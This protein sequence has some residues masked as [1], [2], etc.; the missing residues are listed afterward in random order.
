MWIV[1]LALR[2]PHTFIVMSLAILVA[3]GY[4]V[5]RAPT[6]I[7]PTVDLPVLSVVWVYGGLPTNEF[8]QQITRPAEFALAG[9]VGDIRSMESQTLDGASII[10]VYFQEG[11]DVPS[12]TAQVTA[13]MQAITRIM[14][15]GTQPP[16]IVRYNA[17]SVAIMEVGFSSEVLSEAEVFDFVNRTARQQLST[18]RGARFPLPA[19]GAPRQIVVDIDPDALRARGL[20]PADVTQAIV[21]QN[22]TLPTGNVRMGEQELRV[23]LNSSPPDIASLN[24]MPVQRVDGRTV[25]VRDVAF[26]HD[27]NAIQTNVARRDGTRAIILSVLKSGGDASTTQITA[28]IRELLPRLQASAPPG[29]EIEVLSDQSV[30]VSRA[31]SGLVIEA[32]IAAGLTALLILLFLGSVRST[33]IVITSIPLSILATAVVMRAMGGTVNVM[34]LGGMALAVGILVDDATVEIENVH[35]HLGMGKTLTR[36]ILDGANEIALPALVTSLSIGIVFISLVVLEGPTR[37]LFLPMGLAVGISVMF[38]Y[39]LSRTVVPTMMRSLLRDHTHSH[40]PSSSWFGRGIAAFERGFTRLRSGYETLLNDSLHAR[41]LVLLAF[42]LALGAG[43]FGLTQLGRD[44]FPVIDAGRIRMHLTA[45]P[46]TRIEET[47]RLV[48]RAG[49]VIRRVIPEHDR[50]RILDLVGIPG[51]YTMAVTDTTSMTTADAEI[52]V[53]LSPDRTGSTLD[54]QRALRTAMNEEL[55]EV[56]IHFDAADMMT[57]IANFGISAAVDVQIT[58][59]DRARSLTVARALREELSHVPGL[60]DVRLQQVVDAP[61][62]HIEVDRARLAEAGLTQRDLA[63]SVLLAIGSSGT[64]SPNFWTDPNTNNAFPVI[65]RLPTYRMTSPE[66]LESISVEGGQGVR[67]LSDLATL[68]RR[69]APT[70]G[71]QVDVQPAYNVRAGVDRSDLGAVTDHI[72]R[73]LDRHRADLPPNVQIALRGQPESMS[74]AFRDLGWG[75]LVAALTV[76]ALMVLNFRSWLD[77]AIVLVAIVG[78]SSGIVLALTVTGT[79]LSVPSLMGAIMS[80]GIATSNATLLVTFANEQRMAGM[81]AVD[82][83]RSAG[84]TRLRPILMTSLAMLLGMLPMSLGLGDGGEMNAALA[85]SVIGGLLGSTLTTL[86]VVP[87]VY[88]FVRSREPDRSVDPDLDDTPPLG[89]REA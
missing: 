4:V 78:A 50:T 17:S 75:L 6:D 36:A 5:A 54:Y 66:D 55:P 31:V 37:Y 19:G 32:C 26:V 71:S 10:K 56:R 82:A 40:V 81:S 51:A 84:V 14:P 72:E 18:V 76:Y 1:K 15:P 30:F 86:F 70:V 87:V 52:M 59:M 39:F 46:G 68:T 48:A 49:D 22:L 83:A 62:L 23:S 29:L 77:P 89:A 44:F 27:G 57:Q 38:S 61:R 21:A 35:R 24:D 74:N 8:Q 41:V 34:T 13:A 43:A 63:S 67:Q 3:G 53:N 12:A 65:V 69:V 80:V 60:V 73:I 88:T 45:A 20:S 33:L 42:T 64:V 47:E 85:R 25:F 16:I 7:F 79:T 28:D 11:A 58:S 2:R 9:N